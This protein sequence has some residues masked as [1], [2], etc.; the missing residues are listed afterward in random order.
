MRRLAT[1]TPERSQITLYI[2]LPWRSLGASTV[3]LLRRALGEDWSSVCTEVTAE[4]HLFQE[5]GVPLAILDDSGVTAL[6]PLA[7]PDLSGGIHFLGD[8]SLDPALYLHQLSERVQAQGARFQT[9]TAV[10]G[11][12]T[13]A[14]RITQVVTDRGRFE[15]DHVVLAAGVW[16]RPLAKQL[17]LNLPVQPARGY[18]MTLPRPAA[19]PQR[20]LQ[21]AERRM[22][23]T[24][25]GSLLRC[26]GRL[27]LSRIHPTV[28]PRQIVS[29]QKSL[30]DYLQGSFA[31]TPLETWA[32]LRP[33]TPD[34]LP[35]IGRAP[36]LENLVVATGHGMLG[37]SLAAVTG[38]LV[39]E[40]VCGRPTAIDV[41]PLRV[42]R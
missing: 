42:G 22:A 18:S 8:G 1:S 21:L 41:A 29:L 6:E 36:R 7:R 10:L 30:G 2:S 4:A 12:Q 17:W 39:A 9:N 11:F 33:A 34:G 14:Q 28:D 40:M 5:H 13:N 20:A 31:P 24:P 15:A 3:P 27:E 37:V 38:Q 16:S 23:V 26:T 35:I 32:G 25:M 19:G